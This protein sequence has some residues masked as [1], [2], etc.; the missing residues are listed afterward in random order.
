M[1]RLQAHK[2]RMKVTMALA[3]I[4]YLVAAA[5]L[6]G[7]GLILAAELL[8]VPNNLW[9]E[10][11]AAERLPSAWAI[12]FLIIAGWVSGEFFMAMHEKLQDEAGAD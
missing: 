10:A 4:S 3:V 1:R 8:E 9:W 6:L 11:Q 5:A 2:L 12:L 7:F